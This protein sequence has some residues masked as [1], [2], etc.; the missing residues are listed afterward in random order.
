MWGEE[1]HIMKLPRGMPEKGSSLFS[2]NIL[3]KDPLPLQFKLR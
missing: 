1:E 2:E 3:Y